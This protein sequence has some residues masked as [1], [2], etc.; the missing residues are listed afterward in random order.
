MNKN[1]RAH[2]RALKTNTVSEKR[3]FLNKLW[4]NKL[5]GQ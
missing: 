2:T 4:L 5:I 3:F 1:H